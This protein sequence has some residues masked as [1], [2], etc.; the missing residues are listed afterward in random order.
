MYFSHM[1]DHRHAQ[2]VAALI[3][4][5]APARPLGEVSGS[6]RYEYGRCYL[7]GADLGLETP[8]VVLHYA[9]GRAR[10]IVCGYCAGS[11]GDWTY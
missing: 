4:P 7:C 5:E 1:S 6:V 11:P 8:V 10:G 2:D 9:D 3:A